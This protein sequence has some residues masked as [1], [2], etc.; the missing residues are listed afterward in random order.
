MPDRASTVAKARDAGLG[1]DSRQQG[2]DPYEAALAL[3]VFTY[4]AARTGKRRRGGIAPRST[5]MS[6]LNRRCL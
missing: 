2:M 3:A 6:A 5:L 4:G 1:T